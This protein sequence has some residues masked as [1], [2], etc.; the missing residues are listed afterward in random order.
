MNFPDNKEDLALTLSGPMRKIKQVNL[1][2]L[3]LNLG[4][5]EIVRNN[6]YKDFS[7]QTVL[8]VY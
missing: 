6:K 5:T 7:K 8:C 2:Q 1:N 4:I 3:V